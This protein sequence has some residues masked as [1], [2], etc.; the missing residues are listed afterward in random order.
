MKVLNK[1]THGQVFLCDK[2]EAIHVEFKN[3]AFNFSEKQYQHFLSYIENLDAD[4]W[5]TQNAQSFYQRKII[6]PL[7][8]HNMSLLLN[9]AE[10]NE[11]KDL[12]H[13]RKTKQHFQYVHHAQIKQYNSLN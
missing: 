9:K 13:L 5:E 6:I 2:C 1:S 12:M 10:L 4:Y 7:G 3:F 11:L 8:E